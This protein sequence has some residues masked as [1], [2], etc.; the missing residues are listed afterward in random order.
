MVRPI[1]PCKKSFKLQARRLSTYRIAVCDDEDTTRETLCSLCR[2]ILTEN[3]VACELTAFSPAHELEKRLQPGRFPAVHSKAPGA[4]FF[5]EFAPLRKRRKKAPGLHIFHGIYRKG[6]KFP[7]AIPNTLS[8]SE[9]VEKAPSPARILQAGRRLWSAVFCCTP[10]PPGRFS[11]TKSSQRRGRIQR[12][13]R[14]RI[15]LS[16]SPAD[17]DFDCLQKRLL[18]F[19]LFQQKSAEKALIFSKIRPKATI[20]P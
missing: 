4:L 20:S 10:P 6:H 1:M 12:A 15:L 5:T 7:T 11:H 2:E 19:D 8:N 14:L 18:Y 16:Y 17:C 9:G 13:M 3:S